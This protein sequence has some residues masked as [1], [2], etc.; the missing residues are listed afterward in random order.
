MALTTGEWPAPIPTDR[1]PKPHRPAPQ[2]PRTALS[3]AM[4]V[5]TH[6][7]RRDMA[8]VLA[9]GRQGGGMKAEWLQERAVGHHG[10]R[11]LTPGSYS[12]YSK[13]GAAAGVLAIAC[14]GTMLGSQHLSWSGWPS[15]SAT[16]LTT[17]GGHQHPPA[18][19]QRWPEPLLPLHLPF[20]FVID[21]KNTQIQ[22]RPPPP[23]AAWTG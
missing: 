3:P 6:S 5:F 23:A 19:H 17:P 1:C 11:D 21:L 4:T 16:W 14:P 13:E 20:S 10:A 9:E 7:Y 15:C 22:P 18:D 12:P 8:D 2:V